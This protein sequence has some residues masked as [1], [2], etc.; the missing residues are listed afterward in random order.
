MEDR[1]PIVRVKK[2]GAWYYP[3]DASE[4]DIATA[5]QRAKTLGLDFVVVS[6]PGKQLAEELKQ[7]KVIPGSTNE[8]DNSVWGRT[9]KT[10]HLLQSF[11]L[12][13]I[14][15]TL[16]DPKFA[17]EKMA[18]NALAIIDAVLELCKETGCSEIHFDIEPHT[19]PEWKKTAQESEDEVYSRRKSILNQMNSVLDRVQKRIDTF[20]EELR[21]ETQQAATPRLCSSFALTWWMERKFPQE[22]AKLPVDC[23]YKMCYGGV[24][25]SAEE[26]HDRL[27]GKRPFLKPTV[28]G[29]G[30]DEFGGS[31]AETQQA[32]TKLDARLFGEEEP[33]YLATCLYSLNK[34]AEHDQVLSR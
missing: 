3:R 10:I 2:M 25:K 20:N 15:M 29:V 1:E 17:F 33:S 6:V 14:P 34:L 22:I 18:D 32:A 30:I 28:I 13:V 9:M 8:L 19:L 4:K 7:R 21:L 5:A 16:Q 31:V 26:L 12:D 27:I 23:V 11:G 24:G